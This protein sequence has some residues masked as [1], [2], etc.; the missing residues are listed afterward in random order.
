MTMEDQK[1][2]VYGQ[3][4]YGYHPNPGLQVP[5]HPIPGNECKFHLP[6]F[7]LSF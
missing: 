1:S 6:S 4:G 5:G 2:A 3:N 7:Q